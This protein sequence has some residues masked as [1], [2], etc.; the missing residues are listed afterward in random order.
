M[1]AFLVMNV[2]INALL[3]IDG[4]VL[5]D[6]T[7]SEDVLSGTVAS[8]LVSRHCRWVCSA[9]LSSDLAWRRF[10]ISITKSRCRMR[11]PSSVAPG[12]YRLFPLWYMLESEFFCFLYGRLCRMEFTHWEDW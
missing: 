2:T 7:I 3:Q 11:C 4:T 1:I 9:G 6:G 10:T 8:V 12:L 5:A